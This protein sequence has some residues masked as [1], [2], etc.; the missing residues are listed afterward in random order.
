MPSA[1]EVSRFP[2]NRR[3]IAV[4]VEEQVDAKKVLQLVENVGGNY[5]IGL[6]LFDVYQGQGIEP[7]FKSLAIAMM[8][9]DNER[10]LEESD[11]NDV[12]NRV[13]ETLKSELN[14]SLRD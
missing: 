2:A 10:T 3:D 1:V 11:I 9:Q 4:V 5:L 13:V 6:K 14:A 12:V 7:G 8:L